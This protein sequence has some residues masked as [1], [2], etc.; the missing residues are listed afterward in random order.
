MSDLLKAW[1]KLSSELLYKTPAYR[2]LRETHSHPEVPH[3][4]PF[5]IL[6]THDWV[7]IIALDTDTPRDSAARL[8]MVQQYRVG[9]ESLTWEVPGGRCDAEDATPLQSAAREL[10]EETGASARRWV[11]LGALSPNS[12]LFRNK[13]HTF[14]ALGCTQDPSIVLGDGSEVLKPQW[15]PFAD[16]Y[17]VALGSNQDGH[18][19]VIA[20]FGLLDA[21]LM[22]GGA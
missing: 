6:D 21:W 18:A 1:K 17:E 2:V 11:S 8:L 7:N 5:F 10:R 4:I 19:L 16:R 9:T 15:F 12:A 20:A 13:V 14:L 3:Q 22:R